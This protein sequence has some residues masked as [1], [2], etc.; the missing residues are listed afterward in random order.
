VNRRRLCLG[1]ACLL[2]VAS[3]TAARQALAAAWSPPDKFEPARDAEA[4]IREATAIAKREGK[5][6]IL[7]VGG[8]WCIWCKIMDRFIDGHAELRTLRD[9]RFVWLKINYSKE[10]RN[11]ALLSRYPGIRGYPHLFVLDGEGRLLHSQDTEELEEGKSYQLD[12]FRAFLRKY[13]GAAMV[14]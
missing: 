12:R 1:V 3:A 13:S 8:E 7:D 10:S 6:V 11:E 14:R 9:A 2:A 5:R 4:D